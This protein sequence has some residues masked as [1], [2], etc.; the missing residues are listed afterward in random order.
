MSLGSV[1][2]KEPP[3]SQMAVPSR[4][5]TAWQQISGELSE[6]QRECTEDG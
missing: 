5:L 3:G 4:E 6:L 2:F 1:K